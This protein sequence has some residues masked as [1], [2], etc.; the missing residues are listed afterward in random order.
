MPR[1]TTF[2]A[3]RWRIID[4]FT[5]NR[6]W[7]AMAPT[8]NIKRQTAQSIIKVYRREGR[9][10]ALPRGG[11]R[12]KLDQEMKEFLVTC[13]EEKPTITL[14]ELNTNLQGA[15]PLKPRV[16]NQMI[17]NALDGSMIS[18]KD[19]RAIPV[20]WN[21]QEVK[22]QRSEFMNWMLN[23]GTEKNLVF[24]DEFGINMW[25]SRTKAR[26]VVGHRAVRITAGQRGNNLTFCLAISPQYGHVHIN[27]MIGGMTRERF[28]DMLGETEQLLFDEDVILLLDNARPHLKLPQLLTENHEIRYL[29]KYSPFLNVAEYAGSA[30]KA[31][32]KRAISDPQVQR[33]ADDRVAAA[34]AG[35][36]L[37]QHRLNILQRE[38]ERALPTITQN[39]CRQFFNHVLTYGPACLRMEDIHD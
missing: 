31:A 15:L 18:L 14:N 10:D 17:S 3:D 2:N 1:Q 9:Q 29:P 16:T 37:Q 24:L 27:Y 26:A 39:K 19:V 8:L 32:V 22:N 28:V 11:R 20:N 21:I 36:T 23:E 38:L 7:L 25:T 13:V 12:P 5:E 30:L 6:D 35:N 34:I 33:E 4:A